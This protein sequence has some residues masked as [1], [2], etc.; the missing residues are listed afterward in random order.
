MLQRIRNI[1]Q[2]TWRRCCKVAGTSCKLLDGDVTT[3]QDRLASYLKKMLQRSRKSLLT[4]Q[5]T[6]RNNPPPPRTPPPSPKTWPKQWAPVG[7]GRWRK[8]WWRGPDVE[9]GSWVENLW[10]KNGRS[11]GQKWGKYGEHVIQSL[12]GWIRGQNGCIVIVDM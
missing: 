8:R 1:L 5:T 2:V 3:Y 6:G 12:D 11:M 4:T 9:P 7:P 10:W